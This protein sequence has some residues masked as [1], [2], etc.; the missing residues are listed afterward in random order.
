LCLIPAGGALAAEAGLAAVGAAE[1]VVGGANLVT[2]K[3][4]PLQGPRYSESNFRRNL[5]N[6][7]SIPKGQ[8]NA[9]AH[10]VL[11]QA[12]ESQFKK[13]FPNL[14]IHDPRWGTWVEGGIH[15]GWSKAYQ[16][17]WEQWLAK[18]TNATMAQ[19]EA[20]AAKLAG[21]YGYT[22]P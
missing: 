4:N 16:T 18:N 10:H 12:L 2:I 20:Q 11:P 22:W 13:L 5:E 7:I 17:A 6:R 3:N 21:Q 1:G 15:Q 9:E 14:N 8:K 19:L